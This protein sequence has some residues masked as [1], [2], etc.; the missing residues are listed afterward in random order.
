MAFAIK[1]K[2]GN[3]LDHLEETRVLRKVEH[4]E[5][6]ASIVPVPKKDGSLRLCGDYKVMVNPALNMNQ[7]PLPK[8]ADLLSS[9]AGGQRFSKLDH[10]AAYQQVPL[11]EMSAKLTTINTH[12]GLYE[13]TRLPFGVASAPEIFQRIMVT[14]LQGIPS[15]ICY[16]DDILITGRN[17]AEHLRNLEEVLR[18][19]QK[20]GVRLR[21]KKCHFLQ[22]SVEYLGHCVDNL[23]IHTSNKKVKA[24]LEAPAPRNLQQLRSF[25]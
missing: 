17:G 16:L 1:G 24:I 10:T 3:E 15:V 5:W 22:E 18:H 21:K 25:L 8:P 14:I 6:A 23:G 19:L 7:Y 4:S 11:D 20:H 2:V 13:Y 9:L 12:E